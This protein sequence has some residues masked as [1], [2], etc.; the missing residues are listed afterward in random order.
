MSQK[1]RLNR[2]I[3]AAAGFASRWLSNLAVRPEAVV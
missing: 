3:A 2:I 1:P